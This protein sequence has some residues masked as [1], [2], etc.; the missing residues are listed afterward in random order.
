MVRAKTNTKRCERQPREMK[1]VGKCE[2]KYYW[3]KIAL[4]EL[5][6]KLET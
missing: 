1:E 2:K 5:K 6:R 4:T 3:I